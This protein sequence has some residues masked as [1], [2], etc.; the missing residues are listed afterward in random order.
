ME[1]QSANWI[2]I[3]EVT[4]KLTIPTDTGKMVMVTISLVNVIVKLHLMR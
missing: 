4:S 1:V 3:T 2:A